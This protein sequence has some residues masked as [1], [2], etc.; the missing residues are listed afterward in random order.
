MKI[1]NSMF[2]DL[3]LSVSIQCLHYISSVSMSLILM[4]E[5]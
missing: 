1:R 2:I 3:R 4:K 5:F